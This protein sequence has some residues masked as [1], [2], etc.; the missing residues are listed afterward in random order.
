MLKV[1]SE[2]YELSPIRRSRYNYAELLVFL[3]NFLNVRWKP[4]KVVL[5]D[6]IIEDALCAPRCHH[7]SLK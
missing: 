2:P 7:I 3:P 1:I 5:E 6:T 4:S